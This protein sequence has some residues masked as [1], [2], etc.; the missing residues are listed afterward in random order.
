MSVLHKKLKRINIFQRILYYLT[1]VLYLGALAYFI[2]AILKLKGIETTLRI[3]GIVVLGIW[4]L[5]YILGG[6]ISL[7]TKKVVPFIIMTILTLLLS[8]GL[9]FVSYC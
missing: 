6:L 1:Q 8:G 2:Y 9:I 5:I 7:L 4:A 3:I